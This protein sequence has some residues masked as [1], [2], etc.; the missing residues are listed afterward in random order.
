MTIDVA[1]DYPL[2]RFAPQYIELEAK[3]EYFGLRPQ[4]RPAT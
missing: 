2:S 1:E 4:R 3:D